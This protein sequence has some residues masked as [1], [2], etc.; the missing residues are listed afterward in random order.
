MHQLD[1]N[2]FPEVAPM[3]LDKVETRYIA[4]VLP[5]GISEGLDLS[6][7][8]HTVAW[9]D[10]RGMPI[11][12]LE[13]SLG[14]GIGSVMT[15]RS[16]ANYREFILRCIKVRSESTVASADG[17]IDGLFNDQ[18]DRSVRTLME[19]RDNPYEKGSVRMKASVEFLDRASK[20]PKAKREVEERRTIISIPVS[21]LRTMQ[22]ALIDEGSDGDKEILELLEG[23]DFKSGDD[24]EG[25]GDGEIEITEIV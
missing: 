10:S 2:T 15:M 13:S 22:Q 17:D 11:W 9:L 23:V 5:G 8:A 16:N 21:E 20:A 4:P 24:V 12:A 6:L 1:N 14:L 25:G 18:I 7:E 19:V 3:N